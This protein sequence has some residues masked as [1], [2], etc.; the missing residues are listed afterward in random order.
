MEK[1]ATNGTR[2]FQMRIRILSFRSEQELGCHNARAAVI[3]DPMIDLRLHGTE[4]AMP[5]IGSRVGTTDADQMNLEAVKLFHQLEIRT[6]IVSPTIGEYAVDPSL[7]KPRHRPPVNGINQHKRVGAIDPRLLGGNIGGGRCLPAM[8]GDIVRGEPGIKSFRRKVRDFK[9]IAGIGQGYAL[10]DMR[11]DAMAEGLGIGMRDNDKRVHVEYSCSLI[12]DVG[13][14]LYT[15]GRFLLVSYH[16]YISMSSAKA[17]EQTSDPQPRRRLPREERHRQLLDVAWQ[18]VRDEGTEALTLGRLAEHAG[19]TKPVVYDHFRTRPGLLAAL[20]REYDK[21][22]DALMESALQASEPTLAGRAAVI[23]SSYVDCV[24]LQ[25][26]EIPGVIAALASSPELE[27]I[28]HEYE[29]AFMEKCRLVLAPFAGDRAIASAGLR[30]MLGAAEALSYAA[31]TGEI[32]AA[33]AKDE[34]FESIVAM[35]ARSA[36]SATR[37]ANQA[38]PKRPP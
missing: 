2:G 29:A 26:R 31:A 38:I 15:I 7:K 4:I 6:F 18:L 25:G 35:V 34:L 3:E 36:R 19:V 8:D 5:C 30:A 21:Q 11:S 37:P 27:K 17:R 24:L 22:Q 1:I 14:G 16:W 23:A 28:K 9:G 33:Q 10:S 13:C 20:Y 12:A 32:T